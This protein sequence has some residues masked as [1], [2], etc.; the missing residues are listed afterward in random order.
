M[1]AVK[2]CQ[3][4]TLTDLCVLEYKS[5]WLSSGQSPW[6]TTPPAL[7]FFL[8]KETA[9]PLLYIRAASG[10][11]ILDGHVKKKR[12]DWDRVSREVFFRLNFSS[13]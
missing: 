5:A 9:P 10:R 11:G 7:G 6:G 1:V 4:D 8:A 2:V 3:G 13:K 12:P